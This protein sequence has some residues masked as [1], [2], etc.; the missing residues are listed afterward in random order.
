MMHYCGPDPA[1]WKSRQ[2]LRDFRDAKTP[3]FPP[4]DL[5]LQYWFSVLH[6]RPSGAHYALTCSSGAG[7]IMDGAGVPWFR[8]DVGI[9]GDRITALGVIGMQAPPPSSTRRTWLFRPAHRPA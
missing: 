4:D 5:R 2:V 8:G 9:V 1:F 6:R 3:L 7:R